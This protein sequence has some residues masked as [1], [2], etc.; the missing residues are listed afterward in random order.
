[1]NERFNDQNNDQSN[2]LITSERAHE[3]AQNITTAASNLNDVTKNTGLTIL[4]DEL[5]AGQFQA[6]K[7]LATALMRKSDFYVDQGQTGLDSEDIHTALTALVSTDLIRENQDQEVGYNPERDD[8]S[9]LAALS[10]SMVKAATE[11]QDPKQEMKSALIE[12]INHAGDH[13]LDSFVSQVNTLF[14]SSDD[15]HKSLAKDM[16]VLATERLIKAEPRILEAI[17]EAGNLNDIELADMLNL[18]IIEMD[19]NFEAKPEFDFD[20]GYIGEDGTLHMPESDDEDDLDFQ[21]DEGMTLEEYLFGSD[22]DDKTIEEIEKKQFVD[23]ST[24][25]LDNQLVG[26]VL[27]SQSMKNTEKVDMI[28]F[29]FSSIGRN[30]EFKAVEEIQVSM[31]PEAKATEVSINIDD[32]NEPV[33]ML[34]DLNMPST[35]FAEV[36]LES[37]PQVSTVF[38]IEEEDEL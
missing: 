22:D 37:L 7:N 27:E 9:V 14:L 26:A 10:G 28:R 21:F 38:N 2:A 25:I 8:I 36:A 3:L 11:S 19:D 17:K 15:N 31:I 20:M 12:L 29:I 16:L 1:M 18:Q 32:L 30:P 35:P 23:I 4:A 13:A 33:N 24:Y 5:A 6:R 34:E